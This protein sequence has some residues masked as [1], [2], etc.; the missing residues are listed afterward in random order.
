MEN[1][2]GGMASPPVSDAHR[3]P[4]SFPG[5][6][7]ALAASGESVARQQIFLREIIAFLHRCKQLHSPA[8]VELAKQ[9]LAAL[10]TQGENGAREALRW[11]FHAAR[12]PVLTRGPAPVA[13]D[14]PASPTARGRR[15]TTPPPAAGDVGSSAWEQ[16]LIQA[17][18]S[19]NFLW[20]TEE[21]YRRWAGRFAQFV[22]PR[23][24]Y[25]VGGP[26]VSA[27]LNRVALEQR[28]SASTQKQGLRVKGV[29]HA[30]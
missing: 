25:A 5:W 24:P 10:P 7:E 20:R 27:F 11:F 30:A 4:V 26:E 12:S 19:R 28:A 29:A 22:A 15:M 9:Y 17:M 23:S 18:R 13:V 1:S 2:T 8:S 14:V 16:A 21:T 3:A 6:K